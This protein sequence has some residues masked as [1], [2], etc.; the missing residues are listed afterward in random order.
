MHVCSVGSVQNEEDGA[1]GGSM[2][3]YASHASGHQFWVEHAA[4]HSV[5]W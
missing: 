3:P 1:V 5:L 2:P 4:A